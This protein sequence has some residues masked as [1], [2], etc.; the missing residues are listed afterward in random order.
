MDINHDARRSV[1]IK[2][3]EGLGS[4]EDRRIGVLGLAFKP[5][6]D[7]LREA[8]ALEIIHLLVQEG[9]Q[10]QAYDPA[11]MDH[12]QQLLP[13]V[14]MCGDAY[15]VAQGAHA[16]ILMT[17]WNEFKSLNMKRIK[18]SMLYPLLVDGRNIYDPKEMS[19]LGF[20]YRG[21]GR[22]YDSAQYPNGSVDTVEAQTSES[23]KA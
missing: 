3:R 15:E 12:A 18:E 16:L 9:A 19:A 6:T 22:G 7:D 17:D 20:H 4:L 14:R 13:S 8:P 1:L 21:M 11:A 5:N 10:V 23:V 2:I